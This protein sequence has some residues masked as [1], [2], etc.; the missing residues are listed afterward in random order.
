M[1]ILSLII[2]ASFVT[3]SC[4]K[5][6]NNSTSTQSNVQVPDAPTNLSL[7]L[8]TPTSV[9]LSWTDKSTNET[10]FKIEKKIDGGNFTTFATVGANVTSFKES[11]LST[12][13]SYT[14]R[15]YAYNQGGNS[16][17]YTNTVNIPGY[18]DGIIAYFPFNSNANDES[19]N[20]NNGVVQGATSGNDRF[21]NLNSSYIFNGINSMITINNNT[22]NLNGLFSISFWIKI[23]DITPVIGDAPLIGQWHDEKNTKFLLSYR[24]NGNSEKG[25]S[26]SYNNSNNNNWQSS[27][28]KNWNPFLSQWY[29]CVFTYSPASN[30]SCYIDG[31]LQFSSNT[32]PA[33]LYSPAK[34]QIIVGS[35]WGFNGNV[36]FN[37]EIDDIRFYNR[38]LTANE[39]AYLKSN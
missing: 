37:G 13:S 3:I 6:T 28:A 20:G 25:I 4:T 17:N 36:F 33:S 24:Y 39:I 21:G 9:T 19:N 32:V 16:T 1:R 35:A 27:F 12:N 38:I 5:E 34:N 10:G 30:F 14:Y 23:K 18:R 31:Q 8:N 22:L 2:I 26:F 15:V 29:N 11:N 7:L